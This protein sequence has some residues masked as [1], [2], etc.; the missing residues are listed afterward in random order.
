MAQRWDRRMHK[1]TENLPILQ[2]FV[3]YRGR[4]PK[5]TRK[6]FFKVLSVPLCSH[7][8]YNKFKRTTKNLRHVF[9]G[10][11]GR[12]QLHLEAS[13]INQTR[14]NQRDFLK[15][16][17]GSS[18]QAIPAHSGPVAC[19]CPLQTFNWTI[20]SYN[21]L[22]HRKGIWKLWF[23]SIHPGSSWRAIWAHPWP[24]DWILAVRNC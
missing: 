7:I 19:V 11:P 14:Y 23:P 2:D 20:G 9:G 12:L 21:E 15:T 6:T 4:C 8:N 24:E 13:G 5:S 10:P 16:H 18:W 1:Q 17:P 3:P 22:F